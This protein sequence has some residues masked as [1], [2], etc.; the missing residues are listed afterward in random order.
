MRTLLLSICLF[1]CSLGLA[2]NN[3]HV[4]KVMNQ[5]ISCSDNAAQMVLNYYAIPEGLSFEKIRDEVDELGIRHQSYKQFFNGIEVEGYL[6]IIHSKEGKV[7]S[8]SGSLLQQTPAIIKARIS[9]QTAIRKVIKNVSRDANTEIKY[10]CVNGRIHEVYKY[11]SQEKKETFY[12]DTESGELLQRIPLYQ[13]FYKAPQ[14]G[15]MV[16]GNGYTLY[17]GIQPMDSYCENGVY[18]LLDANRGIITLSAEGNPFNQE[19]LLANMPDSLA[20]ELENIYNNGDT[21]E[22]AQK[23]FSYIMNEY[24]NSCILYSNDEPDWYF[25]TLSSVTISSANSSWWYDIWD[26]EPDLYIKVF[27]HNG[28]CVYTS[29]TIQNATLPVTFTIPFALYLQAPG[30]VVRIYDEDATTDSYGGGVTINSAHAG[31]YTWQDASS[32]TGSLVIAPQPNGLFDVHWGMQNTVD[33]YNDILGRNSY[34]NQGALI[35]NLVYPPHDNSVFQT[36]PNNAAAQS[37]LMPN[38]MFYGKGDGKIMNPVVSLDIMAH[39]FTHLVTNNNGNGGLIYI[40]ESGALNE[41]FSDIMAMGV[42]YNTWGNCTWTIGAGVMVKQNAMRS[43]S[44][45]HLYE[46]PEYYLNDPYW[47]TIPAAQDSTQTLVHTNSGVQNKWFYLLSEGGSG[48]T[49]IGIQNAIQIVYRN[50]I[51]YLSPNA[52]HYDARFGSEMAAKDLFGANSPELAAVRQ[53][54]DIVGVFDQN[55][56]SSVINESSMENDTKKIIRDGHLF[57]IRNGHTYSAIGNLID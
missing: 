5:T 37:N 56:G 16:T 13:N 7:T 57:I 27:D 51:Y 22:F 9:P 48:V 26:T 30:Y 55:A 12:I 18:Y 53:A 35:Y 8:I 33:F 41:S 10:I 38:F 6:L 43:M 32:T 11:I 19:Q 4:R 45:P 42:W 50:L 46:Q 2:T 36:M 49:G 40:D 25:S 20:N 28:D 52:N 47:C 54:W 21:L 1:I 15:T 44:F 17:S 34:D 29:P 24:I 31:T 3:D 14:S 39:E 23:T